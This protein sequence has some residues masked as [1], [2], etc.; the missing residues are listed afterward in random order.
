MRRT[1]KHDSIEIGSRYCCMNDISVTLVAINWQAVLVTLL[2]IALW[3]G[4]A[5]LLRHFFKKRKGT[6]KKSDT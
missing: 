1:W 6:A 5:L 3:I 4:I 2:N